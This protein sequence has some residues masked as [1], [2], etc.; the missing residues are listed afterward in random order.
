MYWNFVLSGAIIIKYQYLNGGVIPLMV[1]RDTLKLVLDRYLG[2]EITQAELSKWAYDIITGDSDMEDRLVTEVLYNLVS[3]KDVSHLFDFHR[4]TREKLR[5]F[6]NCLEDE[7]ECDWE[8]YT[9]IFE[10][11]MLM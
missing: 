5:Y 2:G 1:D 8:Q 10:P 3:F 6:M 11:G 7:K 9:A 4:P